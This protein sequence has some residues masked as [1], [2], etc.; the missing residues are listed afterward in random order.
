MGWCCLGQQANFPLRFDGTHA[1]VDA[2]EA[3][4]P[5][6]FIGER[7]ALDVGGR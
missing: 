1:G 5:D 7:C 2:G 4:M 3:A 6:S